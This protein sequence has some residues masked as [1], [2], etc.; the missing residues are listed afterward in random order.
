MEKDT[1]YF[2]VSQVT[3]LTGVTAA[4]LKNWDKTGVLVARR[5]GDGVANNRK[6][7]ARGDLD[8]VREI[9]LYR[10]LGFGL[11]EIKRVLEA[12]PEVRAQIVAERTSKLKSEFSNIQKQ[13]E[14]S[15]ALEVFEPETLLSE[16]DCDDALSAGDEYS[17]DETLRMMVRWIRSHTEQDAERLTRELS[18]VLEGFF[19]LEED[20]P[21]EEVQLQLLHFCDV[22]SSAFG[23]PTVGQMLTFALI[24]QELASD[25][26]S[27]EG[28]LGGFFG[29]DVVDKLSMVFYLAWADNALRVLDDIL[30]SAYCEVVTSWNSL[31][32]MDLGPLLCTYVCEAS[33]RPHLFKGERDAEHAD[34]LQQA[35]ESVFRLLEEIILDARLGEYLDI[36]SLFTIDQESMDCISTFTKAFA[37]DGLTEWIHSQ[38]FA[39]LVLCYE[40]WFETLHDHWL[41]AQQEEA[42]NDDREAFVAWLLEYYAP[43]LEDPPMARWITE[44]EAIAH[45]KRMR[46]LAQEMIS[47]REAEESIGLEA[48]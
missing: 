35:T 23:W 6:L 40:R 29:E 43:V 3:E 18:E 11:E 31:V 12:V 19:A 41:I 10:S 8:K 47:Q 21:W 30:A 7:Y 33:N 22:W 17:K 4:Q 1:E 24:F 34:E 27:E 26:D 9:Q 14:L 38:G 2:T 39:R 28:E 20:T 37:A 48:D 36:D 42:G 5:T 45:E 44:E 13:I 25:Q 16:L 32:L 15:A 46:S